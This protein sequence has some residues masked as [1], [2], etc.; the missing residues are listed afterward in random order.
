PRSAHRDGCDAAEKIHAQHSY[1]ETQSQECPQYI[2]TPS[3]AQPSQPAFTQPVPNK[4]GPYTH[5]AVCE[6]F[7]AAICG[8]PEAD[9]GKPGAFG[10]PVRDA[11][12]RVCPPPGWTRQIRAVGPQARPRRQAA[13]KVSHT[14]A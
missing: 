13:R 11:Q 1:H 8:G 9:E 5:Q 2:H 7:W 10:G 6:A 12:R 14:A 3:P 4:S